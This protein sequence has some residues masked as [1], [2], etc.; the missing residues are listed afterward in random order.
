VRITVL[1]CTHQRAALLER[2]IASLNA[3]DRPSDA[4][5]NLFVVANACTDGTHRFLEG[6]GARGNAAILPLAWIAEPTPGKSHALNQAFAKID[7]DA[8]AFVDDDHRV[9]GRY[10]VEIANALRTY[11]QADLICGRIL[12]DWDGTEPAWVHD[13]GPYRIY[14]LPVPRFDHGGEPR[15]IGLAGP[16]PGGGNLVARLG[17]IRRNGGFLTELGP[18]GHDLGGAEDLE[19]VRRALRGGAKL[20]YA[21]RI[22]QHHYVERERLTLSYLVRKGF[23]RSKSVMRFRHREPGVPLYMWRKLTEYALRSLLSISTEARRFYLV[24]AASA[25]GEF[26]GMREASQRRRARSRLPWPWQRHALMGLAALAVAGITGMA[27]L[28]PHWLPEVFA[29]TGGL[30]GVVAAALLAKSARDFSQT[31]PRIGRDILH[32]YRVYVWYAMA[33]LGCWVVLV[34]GF[35]AFPGA[36]GGIALS[37]LYGLDPFLVG[38]AGGLATLGSATVYAACSALVKNPGLIIASWQYRTARMYGLWRKLSHRGLRHA[39]RALVG[40]AIVAVTA[41]AA[42]LIAHGHL[43]E[44]GALASAALAY[45]AALGAILWEPL[46]R[47]A[48]A[49]TRSGRPNIVMIGSDTLRADRIG[50]N[51]NGC[52]LTPNIDRLAKRAAYFTSCYVPCARTAPSLIS[53][54]TGTW[55]HTHGIRDNFVED[56]QTIL[57]VATLPELLRALGYRSGAVSDWCGGDL[58]KFSFGFDLA[59]V[60]PDQWNL[61]YFIRQ[62]PKD[63]R[64]FLSL[65]LHNRLGRLCLPEVYFLG[66]VPQ[67]SQLGLRARRT[68]A[69]LAGG[70]EPFF[71]NIFYSTTHPPFGSEHPYYTR[72]ADDSYAGESKF[73]MARLTDPFDII[74]RQGDSRQEFDLDQILALYDSCV[75]QFDDEIGRLMAQLEQSGLVRN[76]IVVLYSDHGMEFFEHETWGQGNSVRGDFSARVPLIIMDPRRESAVTCQRIVRS[77][78]VAP[79]LLD[80]CES[81]AFG[82]EGVSLVPYLEDPSIDMNL[83]ALN[84]TGVWLTDIP[85]MP[86]DHLRYP[87]LLELLDVPDER[88]GTLAIK[89]EYA[90]AII[91]AKDRMVRLGP[92]KLVYQPTST[93]PLVALYHVVNDPACASDLASLRPDVVAQLSRYLDEWLRKDG[94]AT[95][96]SEA[97][98]TPAAKEAAQAG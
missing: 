36:L 74:R 60:P 14:P 22:V 38:M 11:P 20:Q 8:V 26:S 10:L 46:P 49:G 86:A 28:V 64:L 45:A 48:R 29:C 66:G 54:L 37:R 72:Y 34:A 81:R 93:G 3:A 39:A 63:I 84:E 13:T 40:A 31:G 6:Y 57:D 53:L 88:S 79:T 71:L 90:E 69:R 61:R 23:Q 58:A 65:F 91:A 85:G 87:H 56:E 18:T 98:A 97:F 27:L 82:M 24:R 17:I 42:A 77:I 19:W 78:D 5:V 94:I 95:A 15:A 4:E 12:P 55:P 7:G 30:A 9:D 51:R 67:T 52:S 70:D 32:R 92:W 35:W 2:T 59:D 43:L 76:T 21:P 33:R 47:I 16:I 68:L 62:G 44:A 73:A 1:I 25:L 41:L 89:P 50:A 75:A 83:V 80:L 96:V